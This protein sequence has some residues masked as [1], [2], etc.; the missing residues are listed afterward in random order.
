MISEIKSFTFNCHLGWKYSKNKV[1]KGILFWD[2]HFMTENINFTCGVLAQVRVDITWW[3]VS[4]C[5]EN[6]E[7]CP[8]FIVSSV[9]TQCLLKSPLKLKT[10][11][12]YSEGRCQFCQVLGLSCTAVGWMIWMNYHWH[13]QNSP[14]DTKF[15]TWCFSWLLWWCQNIFWVKLFRTMQWVPYN[16]PVCEGNVEIKPSFLCGKMSVEGGTLSSKESFGS[17]QYS[18]GKIS[19]H[20]RNVFRRELKAVSRM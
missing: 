12:D 7:E 10:K 6:S 17:F 11:K 2:C 14:H 16:H 9:I 19:T 18:V 13:K 8:W 3:K 20:D 4:R 15:R 1:V 5:L